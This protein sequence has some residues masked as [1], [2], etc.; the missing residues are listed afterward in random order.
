MGSYIPN[1][2]AERRQM[3]TEAGCKDFSD[4]YRDIPESVRLRGGLKLPAGKS[5]MEV[6]DILTGL[7]A[8]NKVYR[9]IF[10]GAG[11]YNHYIPAIVSSVVSKEEFV[12]AYTP[13]QPEISQGVLQYIFEYQTMICDLTGM[14]VSNASMYDGAEATAEAIP[15]CTERK[16]GRVLISASVNPSVLSTVKTYCFGSGHEVTVVPLNEGRTDFEKLRS[17]LTEDAACVIVQQ[18][19]YF[20]LIEDT[21]A[22]AELTHAA[23]ARFVLNTYPMALALLRTPGS[24]GADVA[25]GEGQPLG[26]PMSFGGPYLGYM[27]ATKAMMRRLPGRIVGQTHDEKGSRVFVLTLQA[28]EQ[29]IRREKASSN[30]CSNESLCTLA[31]GTYL[32][33]LGPDGFRD[34][35]SQSVS[36]AHYLAERLQ[37]AGLKLK[38]PGEFFNEFVTVGGSAEKILARLEAEDILGGLPLSDGS[39]LWCCTEMCS[40]SEMDKAAALVKEAAE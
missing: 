22:L 21:A 35:A 7:A 30:I 2:D 36:K 1:A 13:Y 40:R 15:M 27:A 26:L 38:Y 31:A 17:L 9:S 39:M 34:A 11:S 33:A 8:E 29:H 28:R 20:G 23:G 6:R 5:E 24:I 3:L 37:E 16:R 4:L 18:P 12:T 19:N 10:R 25:V 14:D 32:S